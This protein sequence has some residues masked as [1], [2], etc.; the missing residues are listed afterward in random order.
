MKEQKGA[1]PEATPGA[2]TV[3]KGMGGG[4]ASHVNFRSGI[5]DVSTSPGIFQAFDLM[6]RVLFNSL[7]D[8][9]IADKSKHIADNLTEFNNFVLEQIGK[10]EPTAVAEEMVEEHKRYITALKEDGNAEAIEPDAVI[11]MMAELVVLLREALGKPTDEPTDETAETTVEKGADAPL[12]MVHKVA[13]MM[14]GVAAKFEGVSN[15]LDAVEKGVIGRRGVSEVTETPE[16]KMRQK[17]S[18]DDG[19]Y[20]NL[21]PWGHRPPGNDEY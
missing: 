15:R 12:N 8:A 5:T 20:D 11:G 18:K 16:S 10:F 9:N 4:P 14:E 1:A 17:R 3:T 7:N 21:F 2:E 6:Q 13:E 19:V